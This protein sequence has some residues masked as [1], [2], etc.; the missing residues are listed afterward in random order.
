[1]AWHLDSLVDVILLSYK[2]LNNY[3]KKCNCFNIPIIIICLYKDHLNA[4]CLLK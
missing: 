2:M 4:L 3:V 1:M